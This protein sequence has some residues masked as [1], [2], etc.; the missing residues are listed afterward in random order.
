VSGQ[1][2]IVPLEAV[3]A[4]GERSLGPEAR[5]VLEEQAMLAEN[6]QED[7]FAGRLG[8][9]GAVVGNILAGAGWTEV[10]RALSDAVERGKR[11]GNGQAF[12]AALR[13]FLAQRSDLER[14]IGGPAI[15]VDYSA[16]AIGYSENSTDDYEIDDPASEADDPESGIDHLASGLGDGGSGTPERQTGDI[17][18]EH[19]ARAA[20]PARALR[21]DVGR[22]DALVNLAGELLVARNAVGHTARLA[23]DRAD[24][25]LLARLLKDQ[26]A[27]LERLVDELRRSVLGMRVLPL[28]HVFQNFPRLAREM[29]RDLGKAVKLLIE[30]ETTEA[31][32]AVV[33]ALF[34]P[35]LHVVRNAVDHGIES[36]AE[37]RRAGKSPSATVSLRAMRDGDHVIVEIADDGRGIDTAEIRRTAA[38]RGLATPEDLA[39]MTDEAITELIF[40]PGFSTAAAVTDVSGRGVGMDAVRSAIAG[41]GGTV[42]VVSR[43]G[44]GTTVRFT[45]PFSVMMQR[46]MTVEAG[47]QI[48][49]IP[50][51]AVIE[52]TR[53]AHGGISRIGAAE[54]VVLRGRTVPLIRLTE[55]L[56]LPHAPPRDLSRAP[57]RD[58]S[59]APSRDPRSAAMAADSTD[60]GV[61]VATVGG[62]I[63]ALRVDGFGERMDVM[64]KP[65]EGLLAGVGGFAGTTLLGDGRVLVV[66]DLQ[67]LL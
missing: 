59:H 12:A 63:V 13:S 26:H 11:E 51:E 3:I 30:G 23:R 42:A 65:M 33:E 57:P 29:A 8:S 48:F 66:L 27:L 37:R 67:D 40:S 28:R 45:L 35:M 16:S 17:E 41:L 34:E 15:R 55:L 50:I 7:G 52:T 2:E 39:R 62:Q 47:G 56:D 36:E 44:S 53:I 43:P 10:S 9:A 24:P 20:R 46:V 58:L 21:V 6:A 32:K 38:R 4:A 49:G 31:D 5:A 19:G 14:G 64:L 25:E 61:V 1:V 54:A 60:A 18:T 22:I